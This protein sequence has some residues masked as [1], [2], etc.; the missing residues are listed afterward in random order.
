[1]NGFGGDSTL[2]RKLNTRQEKDEVKSTV[3]IGFIYTGK[4]KQKDRNTLADHYYL[5]LWK[6]HLIINMFDI[7]CFSTLL[8]PSLFNKA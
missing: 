6:W 7:L 5:H 1:M 3:G 2:S 4:L 8:L